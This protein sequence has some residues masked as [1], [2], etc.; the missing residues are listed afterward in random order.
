MFSR[1]FIAYRPTV[2][3]NR[4]IVNLIRFLTNPYPSNYKNSNTKYN[5][6]E[7]AQFIMVRNVHNF[8]Q[9]GITAKTL[10]YTNSL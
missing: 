8:S 9:N 2:E 3:N 6:Y 4:D 5:V 1:Q 7:S 10:Y